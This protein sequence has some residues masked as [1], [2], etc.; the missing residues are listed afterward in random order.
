MKSIWKIDISTYL[1]ILISLLSGLYK[2]IF[3][4]LVILLFHEF[5][6]LFFFRLFHIS[7]K[8]ITIY[9]FGGIMIVDKKCH[10]R[11]YKE[12]LCSIG[13]ILFQ[14]I[15]LLF[16]IFLYQI[17]FIDNYFYYLFL[18]YNFSIFIFNLI[19]LIPLDGSKVLF[20]FCSKYFS[21][22]FSYYCML[23][24]SFISTFVFI[25]VNYI[26]GRYDFVIYVFLFIQF[27]I[28]LKNMKYIMYEYYMEK[29][30][31][32]HYYDGIIYCDS[33]QEMRK[34]KYYY[35]HGMNERNFLLKKIDYSKK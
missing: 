34:D 23:W 11:I 3:L 30:L 32:S 14:C 18:Q 17:R 16:F 24:I 22:K 13:G 26:Y 4:I 9:P 27:I 12:V 1:F 28:Y 25:Y 31:Y 8:K 15:L 6:H 19:P 29:I 5:G 21:Y 2:D 20:H 35:I 10:E 33:F 7:V